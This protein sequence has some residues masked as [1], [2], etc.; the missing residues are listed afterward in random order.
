MFH[1]STGFISHVR[2][3]KRDVWK[4]ANKTFEGDGRVFC[5]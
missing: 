2:L 3:R 1:N 5:N 4:G